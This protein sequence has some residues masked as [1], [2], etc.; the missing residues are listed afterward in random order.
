MKIGKKIEHLIKNSVAALLRAVLE[1]NPKIPSPPYGRLLFMRYDALGDM[2]LSFPVYRAARETL[3][4]AQID[5]LCSR[6]NVILLR[7]TNLANTL[8]VSEKNPLNLLKLILNIRRQKYDLI[9]NL[10]TR[11]SFTFGLVAR[12]GGPKSVRIAGD[13]EQFSYFYNRVI[14]LP[15]KSDIHMMKRKFLVCKDFLDP[16]ISHTDQPWVEYDMEVKNQARDLFG[17]IVNDL[18]LELQKTR[19]A[20]LNL[21]AGLE[22]REWPVD[23][24]VQF[25]GQCVEK[26]K[27]DIDGWVVFTDPG[28]PEK[29]NKLVETV[30]SLVNTNVEAVREPPLPKRLVALPAQKDIRVI[31]EFLPYLKVLITPDTSIAHAASAMGTPVMVLTIG[32]NVNVWNPIGV[33]HK[34]VFSDDPFSL[35]TLPMEKVAE[36]FDQLMGKLKSKK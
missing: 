16:E 13:Q 18:E 33:T 28:K 27:D 3:P 23:K 20:A 25:L 5:V 19:F 9:I 1:Q 34:I 2:I 4:Q 36:G 22:R 14:D 6:K 32:E 11:P 15:P 24:Y 30:N 26:Y 35:E 8:L 17:H 21:S 12:L 10:V 7:G 31:L 29:A